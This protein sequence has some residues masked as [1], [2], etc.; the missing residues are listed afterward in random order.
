[1]ELALCDAPQGSLDSHRSQSLQLPPLGGSLKFLKEREEED[2][3][4][5]EKP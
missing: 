2:S 5:V 3:C 4:E 1:M